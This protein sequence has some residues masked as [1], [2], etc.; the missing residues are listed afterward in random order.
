MGSFDYK[1]GGIIGTRPVQDVRSGGN[2]GNALVKSIR[3][4]GALNK[5]K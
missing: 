2:A 4:S 5:R 1:T 3:N